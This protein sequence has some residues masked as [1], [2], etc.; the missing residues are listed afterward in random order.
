MKHNRRPKSYGHTRN[1]AFGLKNMAFENK[2]APADTDQTARGTEEVI[3][4]NK[5]TDFLDLSQAERSEFSLGYQ[6]TDNLDEACNSSGSN[7]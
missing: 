5:Q 3:P 6:E 1:G 2:A 4:P 7:R